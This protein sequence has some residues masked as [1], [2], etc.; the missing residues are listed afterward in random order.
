MHRIRLFSQISFLTIF[1]FLFI[2]TDYTGEP[3]I[4]TAVRFF[5]EA[6]P[7][8]ALVILLKHKGIPQGLSRLFI[9]SGVVMVLTVLLGRFFCG[10]VCPLGSIHHGAGFEKKPTKKRI[11]KSIYHPS[12]RIKYLVLLILLVQ[13]L[14]SIQMAGI[15]DPISLLIRSL[16]IS[17]L[18]AVHIA[19]EQISTVILN[20]NPPVITDVSEFFYGLLKNNVLPFNVQYFY[21]N[22]FIAGLFSL[23]LVLNRIRPRFW[24]RFICPL[25]ALLGCSSTYN[26]IQRKVSEKCTECNICH[27]SCQGAP[28]KEGAKDWNP[29]ECFLCFNCQNVCPEE[30]VSFHVRLDK[31]EKVRNIMPGRRAILAS[32][33]SALL[34]VPVMHASPH[35]NLPNPK[36]I[37][38]PGSLEESEFLNRCIRCGECMKVCPTNGLHPTLLEAGLEGIWSPMF[39]MSMGYCEY[40]CTLCGQVC[41]TGA[42]QLLSENEKL[43]TRIGLAFF[44]TTRCLPYAF[45]IS[46]IVCEEHCPTHKKAIIFEERESLDYKNEK[47]LLKFPRV[48][49]DLCIGCG[50]CENKCPVIDKRAIRVTSIGESRSEENQLILAPKDPYS[51]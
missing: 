20:Y 17:V 12:Q 24:C 34:A 2:K 40:S 49:P 4:N 42:I 3:Y 7:L 36:L 22:L 35:R 28:A 39:N 10:W 21:Q 13:S 11:K 37:R 45:G 46:C 43:K 47:K 23:I 1:L 6:D 41:P 26:R 14:F 9:L 18:P 5:L 48:D 27:A 51:F 29:Q 15:F 31:K 50:I 33:G 44:D 32:A 30:A 19:A 16:T 8:V 38:P 25:G